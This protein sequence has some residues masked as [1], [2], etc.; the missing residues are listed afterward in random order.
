MSLQRAEDAHTADVRKAEDKL[1]SEKHKADDKALVCMIAF[2]FGPL[3]HL[4][5][6][7]QASKH[8]A[9]DKLKADTHKADT[10]L[11][12]RV[13]LPFDALPTRPHFPSFFLGGKGKSRPVIGCEDSLRCG[14]LAVKEA[15]S[16]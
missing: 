7:R 16:A 11:K 15:R 13:H 2:L 6:V 8:A 5:V 4:S 12:V 1:A 3:P 14:G 10:K 9:E